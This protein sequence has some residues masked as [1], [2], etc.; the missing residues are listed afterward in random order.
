[1]YN[2]EL[3]DDARRLDIINKQYELSGYGIFIP[4]TCKCACGF[5]FVDYPRAYEELIT[6]CPS[7]FKTYCE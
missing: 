2:N 4:M 1:M 5:D 6:G 7:C 3:D